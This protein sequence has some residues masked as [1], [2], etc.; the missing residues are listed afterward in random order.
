MKSFFSPVGFVVGLI[1]LIPYIFLEKQWD[2]FATFVCVTSVV[3]AAIMIVEF[4]LKNNRK[5]R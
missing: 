5:H 1:F 4:F 3:L 2:S